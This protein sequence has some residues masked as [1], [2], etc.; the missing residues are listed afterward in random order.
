MPSLV[1]ATADT[2]TASAASADSATML[3]SNPSEELLFGPGTLFGSST[4]FGD[5]QPA[6]AG[7]SSDAAGLSP[8]TVDTLTLGTP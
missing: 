8:A 4:L 1:P 5:I 3:S 6:F 2:L 7:A